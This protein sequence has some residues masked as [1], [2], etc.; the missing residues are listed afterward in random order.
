[1]SLIGYARV[2]TGEQNLDLQRDALNA[3]ARKESKDLYLK[4]GPPGTNE[5]PWLVDPDTVSAP[6]LG[7]RYDIDFREMVS[8]Q[9]ENWFAPGTFG[10]MYEVNIAADPADFLDW[11]APLSAQP[12]GPTRALRSVFDSKYGAGSFDSYVAETGADYRDILHNFDDWS[13]ASQAADLRRE[14]VAGIRYLDGGSRG[15]GTPTGGKGT[16]NFVVFDDRLISIVRKYGIAGAAAML[17]VSAQEV[18]TA[19]D[20]G[21]I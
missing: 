16:R 2:S 4:Y 19:M 12:E 21:G 20:E 15:D 18:Q 1:M 8:S 3:A 6:S 17:G 11:D 5:R 10:R 13:E 9:N 14:G 7:P